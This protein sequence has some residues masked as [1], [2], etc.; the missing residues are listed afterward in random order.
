LTTMAREADVH[1]GR[2]ARVAP[3]FK[4][5]TAQVVAGHLSM[6]EMPVKVA[7]YLKLD[8]QSFELVSNTV[9]NL[10]MR[11]PRPANRKVASAIPSMVS[12][13]YSTG[14]RPMDELDGIFD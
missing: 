11:S 12:E 3:A 2:F 9:N 6:S 7:E 1:R 14:S 13:D 4:L 10:I 8:T 5:A